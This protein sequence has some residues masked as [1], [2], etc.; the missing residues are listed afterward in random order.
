MI[1]G[2]HISVATNK[3]FNPDPRNRSG[4]TGLKIVIGCPMKNTPNDGNSFGG[5]QYH[6][7]LDNID[8]VD[9]YRMLLPGRVCVYY[10]NITSDLWEQTAIIYPP[11]YTLGNNW[12]RESNNDPL[13][14]EFGYTVELNNNGDKLFVGSPFYRRKLGNRFDWCGGVRVYT[15]DGESFNYSDTIVTNYHWYHNPFAYDSHGWRLPGMDG[16]SLDYIT[17]SFQYMRGAGASI[18]I[19]SD[20]GRI[21]IGNPFLK[22]IKV[23]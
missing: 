14:E 2:G 10:Y 5:T 22:V 17:G 11:D 8:G 12:Y 7:M 23:V 16:N 20:G 3:S 6:G 21:I 4:K 1:W 15:S 18:S 9:S 13:R 19:S